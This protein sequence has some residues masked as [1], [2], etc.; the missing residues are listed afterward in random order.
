MI[1]VFVAQDYLILRNI[2]LIVFVHSFFGVHLSHDVIVEIVVFNYTVRKA[3]SIWNHSPCTTCHLYWLSVDEN[4]EVVN[5][6]HIEL[7]GD[8]Q[9]IVYKIKVL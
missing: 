1:V 9:F 4:L 7:I 2:I 3:F 6:F 5:S 8:L